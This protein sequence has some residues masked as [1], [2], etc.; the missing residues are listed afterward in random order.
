M[1]EEKRKRFPFPFLEL[2]NP[3]EA[4]ERF[5]E[6][7]S[8]LDKVARRVDRTLG[9][10]TPSFEPARLVPPPIRLKEEYARELIGDL[11]R[12]EEQT[13]RGLDLL[14]GGKLR[15]AATL[16]ME[17]SDKI[18]EKCPPCADVLRK[19]ALEAGLAATSKNLGERDWRNY[20]NRAEETLT[21]LRRSVIPR[22][23][24]SIEISR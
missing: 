17:T 20:L 5:N 6:L 19:S 7:V 3:V 8:D 1:S 11:E 16:L 24:K 18:E 14:R 15:E 13:G 21:R 12:V 10:P 22:V 9:T 23:K 4:L 2:P